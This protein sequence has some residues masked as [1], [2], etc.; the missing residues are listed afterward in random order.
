MIESYV[1]ESNDAAVVFEIVVR[2]VSVFIFEFFENLVFCFLNFQKVVHFQICTMP[3][4]Y[5]IYSHLYWDF[6]SDYLCEASR[7]VPHSLVY[8]FST[9]LVF[10]KVWIIRIIRS[11]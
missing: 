10:E 2:F 1:C 11:T 9:F 3:T 5:R 8:T 4:E 6:D 7:L